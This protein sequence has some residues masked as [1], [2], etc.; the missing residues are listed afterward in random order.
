MR[1]GMHIW[2]DQNARVWRWTAFYGDKTGWG[3]GVNELNCVSQ[4]DAWLDNLRLARNAEGTA[5]A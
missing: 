1:Q 3:S 5:K 4:A 2:P